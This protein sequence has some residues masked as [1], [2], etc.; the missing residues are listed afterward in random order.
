[1]SLRVSLDRG[2]TWTR[3][4]NNFPTVAV[5]DLK[6][7]PRELD[8]IIGTHGRSIWTM[9]IN[10]LEGLTKEQMAKDGAALKPQNVYLL[11]R[12]GSPWFGGDSLFITPNTQPGTKLFYYLKQP[13]SGEVT[14]KVMSADESQT[15]T[16][17]GT[18]NAGMNV[19]N[20]NGRLGGRVAAAGDYRVVVSAGGKE[21]V[22]SVRVEDLSTN[23]NE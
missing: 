20:W 12:V 18:N 1:M 10:G 19:V 16:L 7:H 23:R 13:V 14:V 2:Q 17:T 11:G 5:H 4:R 9:D 6:I 22:T 15:E 3:L 8:L 21:Y